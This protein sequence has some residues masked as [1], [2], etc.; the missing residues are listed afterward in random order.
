MINILLTQGRVT[1]IDDADAHLAR[2]KWFYGEGYAGRRK[3]GMLHHC[4]VGFPL[5]GLVVDH[6]NRDTLDNRRVNLRIVT[7][8]E[9]L[10][11]SSRINVNPRDAVEVRFCGVEYKTNLLLGKRGRQ[12]NDIQKRALLAWCENDDCGEPIYEGDRHIEEI[13][14]EGSRYFYHTDCARKVTTPDSVQEN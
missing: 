3:D 5:D 10:L 6:I 7:Q 2:Y 12:M 14:D 8:R 1:V 9:N 11:N 13:S 4:I